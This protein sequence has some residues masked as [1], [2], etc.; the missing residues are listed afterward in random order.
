M[1]LTYGLFFGALFVIVGGGAAAII[2][3]EISLGRARP[4]RLERRK[5]ELRLRAPFEKRAARQLRR[6][7]LRELR[8]MAAVRKDLEGDRSAGK[9]PEGVVRD[10]ERA[11]QVARNE[12]ARAEV[13]LQR[14]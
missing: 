3:G 10:L 1:D 8:G 4:E 13:W 12:I 5:A 7:L 9:S 14:D 6:L 11:E 2:L